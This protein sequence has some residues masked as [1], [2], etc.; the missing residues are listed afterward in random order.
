M[1]FFYFTAMAGELLDEEM[2]N[3]LVLIGIVTTW[4]LAFVVSTP[5]R[6][7][8]LVAVAVVLT[9]AV[10]FPRRDYPLALHLS[11][12]GWGCVVVVLYFTL[13]MQQGRPNIIF[14]SVSYAVLALCSGVLLAKMTT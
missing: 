4:S 13:G 3:L 5:M 12:L 10:V 14:S 9:T 1:I 7:G 6:L 8:Q 2:M 11:G